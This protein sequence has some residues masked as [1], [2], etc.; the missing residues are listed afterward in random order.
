MN[1]PQP[2]SQPKQSL[3]QELLA[4]RRSLTDRTP[5]SQQICARF[6]QAFPLASGG[7]SLV[8]VSVRDEVETLALVASLLQT[9]G[10]VVVPY[11]LPDYQLG[12]FP[13]RHISELQ[14]GAYGILEPDEQLRTE[15]SVD[16][17]TLDIA[18]VPG[19]G[20]DPFGNRLGYGKGYFD[21]LLS[22]LR[23]ECV[24][25][26]LAFECQLVP[27]IVAQPHDVAMQYIVTEQQTLTCKA[28]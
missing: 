6:R 16:P 25:V 2:A 14:K 22:R 1:S 12:L 4:A 15:R 18:V 9:Q 11:C 28:S 5:R 27:V 10:E 13:L 3:R 20:F 24:K 8:Y 23:P 7:R 17:Q 19:V 21:R 26:A